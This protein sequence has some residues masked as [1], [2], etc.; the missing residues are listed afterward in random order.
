MPEVKEIARLEADSKGG[1]GAVREILEFI[2]KAQ[3][4]W[5]MATASF[6]GEAKNDFCAQ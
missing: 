4:L 3:G 1:D 6:L 2:I 5:E